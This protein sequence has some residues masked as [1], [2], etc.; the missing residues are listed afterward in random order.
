MPLAIPGLP[1][2]ENEGN[3]SPQLRAKGGGG[4]AEGTKSS[5]TVLQHG[6]E[7]LFMLVLQ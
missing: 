3:V 1:Y 6:L 4:S 5:L 2:D 7:S